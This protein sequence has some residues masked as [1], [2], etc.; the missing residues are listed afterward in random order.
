MQFH[1]NRLKLILSWVAAWS[2]TIDFFLFL[3]RFL[4]KFNEFY[5]IKKLSMNS[6]HHYSWIPYRIHGWCALLM[7][8]GYTYLWIILHSGIILNY[9]W[10]LFALSL[11]SL[12]LLM[13]T[14]TVYTETVYN[15]S[16]S[17][18]STRNLNKNRKKSIDHYCW[19][20]ISN[21]RIVLHRSLGKQ[22]KI[23]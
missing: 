13:D 8:N 19:C 16:N 18:N 21:G 23:I 9:P 20:G 15:S 1:R 11:Y 3:F 17:T 12:K 6:E 22:K 5:R 2:T 14:V 10:K 7:D 4:V